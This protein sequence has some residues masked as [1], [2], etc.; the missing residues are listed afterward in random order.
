[1]SRELPTT[2]GHI[3]AAYFVWLCSPACTKIARSVWDGTLHFSKLLSH[4]H[5]FTSHTFAIPQF[6][7]AIMT[8]EKGHSCGSIW[9]MLTTDNAN[10]AIQGSLHMFHRGDTYLVNGLASPGILQALARATQALIPVNPI[11]PAAMF[12][13]GMMPTVNPS[14]MTCS[15]G[16]AVRLYTDT[17]RNIHVS[18]WLHFRQSSAIGICKLRVLWQ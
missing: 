16:A 10:N 6:P 1:M 12:R 11:R 3:I 17:C 7:R 18:R 5:H 13:L 8:I 9:S 14:F 15:N 2:G 4:F